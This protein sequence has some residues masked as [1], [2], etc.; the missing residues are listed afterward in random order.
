M[1]EPMFRPRSAVE[2]V[3]LGF[4]TY[5]AHFVTLFAIWGMLIA[6][7]NI[8]GVLIGGALGST[9]SNLSSLMMPIAIGAT[10]AVV[11]D[12]MHDRPVS[13]G[14]AFGQID[15]RWGS[16][17]LLSFAQGMLIVIGLVLL[18]IPGVVMMCWT[19]AAPMAVVVERVS[20]TAGA[21]N[22]SKELAR[23]QFWHILG[24]IALSWL[25]FFV[26]VFAAGIGIGLV[27]KSIGLSEMIRAMIFS[28]IV[29]LGLPVFGASSG[30][31]YFDI[32]VRNDAYD[33]E[34]LAQTLEESTV[35]PATS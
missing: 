25:I 29:I 34:R 27:A 13:L 21:I 5:R 11:S 30:V 8:A 15:G 2:I 3:D 6:P 32:R 4:S 26:L 23:G 7:F 9:V 14:S 35:T 12:A 16:L 20:S 24:T 22:R 1:S 33:V 10:V 17:V 28:W 31:L 19:F 18:V